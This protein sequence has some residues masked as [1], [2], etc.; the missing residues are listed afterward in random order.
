MRDDAVESNLRGRIGSC[1]SLRPSLFQKL[2]F[3]VKLD[4]VQNELYWFCSS[5]YFLWISL[6]EIIQSL[7]T[8]ALRLLPPHSTRFPRYI[9]AVPIRIFA[10]LKLI[11]GVSRFALH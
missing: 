3:L 1:D 10:I 4:Q 6:L 7:G 5:Q 8:T 9:V 11:T 2:G